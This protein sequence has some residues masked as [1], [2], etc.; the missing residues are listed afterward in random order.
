MAKQKL[1]IGDIV[2]V[3]GYRPVKYVP[4]VMDEMGTEDLFKSMVGKRYR[5]CGFD[6]YGHIELRPKRLDT[7]WIEAEL[8]ELAGSQPASAE[9]IVPKVEHSRPRG[10]DHRGEKIVLLDSPDPGAADRLQA[11]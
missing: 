1:K 2:R 8:V 7:V 3:T 9:F 6:Q 11:S 5:V 4:G 10:L